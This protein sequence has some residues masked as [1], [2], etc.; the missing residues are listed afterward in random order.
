MRATR[1]VVPWVPALL[2]L[3][4]PG[5]APAI[6]SAGETPPEI[7]WKKLKLNDAFLCEGASFG[8]FDKDGKADVVSGPYWYAGPDFTKRHAL[9]EVHPFDPHKYSDNFFAF[10]YD[11]DKDGW[12][13]VLFIGFPGEGAWWARNPGP[14]LAGDPVWARHDVFKEVSGESPTFVDVNGDGLPD[15][16]GRSHSPETPTSKSLSCWC[17]ATFDPDH[18]EKEW[19]CH[20]ISGDVGEGP[21]FH[22]MGVG[23]INGDG[24]PDLIERTG[25]WEQPKDLKGDPV[26]TQ[27]EVVFSSGH[28]GAQM[29]VTD[30]DGDG[31]ADVITSISAH[32]YGLSWFEQDRQKVLGYEKIRFVE[33]HLMGEKPEECT[34]GISFTELHALA[35]ADVDG[36]G[37][38]D[39]VTGKRFW[40]HGPTGSPGAGD[41]SVLYWWKL[42]RKDG[43]ADFEPHPIDDDSGVGTQV[44]AGDVDGDGKTDVVV[45]NKKGTFVLLQQAAPADG[46]KKQSKGGDLEPREQGSLPLG[47]DGHP[48]NTDFETGDLRD[49]TSEDAAFA[50][51]PVRGDLSAARQRE[52]SR[53]RGDYW[54]GG[55]EL[56][57]D[58]PHGELLS[59]PFKVTK[60]WASFLVGG[61]AGEGTAVELVRDG[62]PQSF[63]RCTGANFESMQPIAVDLHAELGA[64]IRIRLVDDSSDG[65]GHLNFD[66]FRVHDREPKCERALGVPEILTPDPILHA[67]L[68]PAEAAKAMVIPPGFHVDVI[69]GEP[70]VHQPIALAIDGK[71]RL[72]VVEAVSYPWRQKEGEGKDDIVVF[73]DRDGDGTFETRTV[74]A[75]HLNLVSGIEIGFGGVFVGAAPYLEFIPDKNDDLRPDGPP[76]VLLDGFGYEDTHETLNAF[77]WGPDGWLYGCHGVFTHSRVGKPGTPDDQRIPMNAAI[78][79]YQ[80][81][82]HEFEIFAEGTSNPWG[83]DFDDHGDSFC[84]AC[85]IPHLYHIIQ[86]GRYIRQAGEHFEPYGYTEID[87]IADHRHWA[88]SGPYAAIGRSG[89][90]GGGHAHCGALIY[91]GDQFP[92]SFRNTIIMGNIHGNRVN[93]DRFEAKGSGFVG[94]HGPDFILGNDKW[95]RPINE[96]TGPD[97]SVYFI[98]WYDKHACH[99]TPGELWDRTNGRIYRIRYGDLKPRKGDLTL[100]T[101]KR[102]DATN[103]GPVRVTHPTEPERQLVQLQLEKNDW[104]CRQARIELQAWA[105]RNGPRDADELMRRFPEVERSLRGILANYADPTRRL[106]AMWT[107]H[108][109][110]KFTEDDAILLFDDLDPHVRG[111]GVQLACEKKSAGPELLARMAKAAAT[112]DSPIVRRFLASAAQRLPLAD[113]WPIVEALIRHERDADD[114]NLPHL[115]WYALEPLVPADP[116]RALTLALDPK[117][118]PIESLRRFIVRRAAAT[119]A[120]HVTLVKALAQT[121]DPGE[122]RWMLDEAHTALKEQRGL[123]TPAGWPA[124]YEKLRT[125]PDLRREAL[126]VAIDFG[127]ASALPELRAVVIVKGGRGDAAW[128]KRALDAI[129]RAKDPQ[130]PM[131]LMQMLDDPELR[132]PSLRALAGFADDG[133]PYAILATMKA[134]KR[135]FTPDERRD[136]L[137][138]LSARAS[139]AKP[140]LAALGQDE[141]PRADFA[142]TVLRRLRDLR[143]PEVDALVAKHFGVSRESPDDKRQ[144]IAALKQALSP[145]VLSGADHENGRAI[146]SSICMKCH[147]LFGTGRAI[148][149]DLTGANRADL[150]Y[151]LSNVVDPNAVIGKEYQVT[152]VWLK[153]GNVV[154]GI[155]SKENDS[156]LTLIAENETVVVAKSDVESRKLSAVSLMPEGQLDPLSPEDV[157]DLFAY[158]QSPAQVPMKATAASAALLFDQKSLQCWTGD[159]SLWS[160]EQGEIV[161]KTAKGLARNAFL[162]SDLELGDFKLTLEVKLVDDAGN[163]GV[164]FRTEPL[165]P[166]PG[167]PFDFEVKG[168]QADVGPGWWGKLY[169]ENGRGLL[170][171][172]DGTVGGQPFLKK[173]DWNAYEIVATGSRIRLSLNGHVT[174]DVD[175]PAAAKRGRIALQLHSG[176]P[177]EVRF[178]NL[179]LELSPPPLPPAP[180]L[181]PAE[182]R[183]G[184]P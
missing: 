174:A 76:E 60:P 105:A 129:V 180:A 157:R 172:N 94:H 95:F 147:T 143:D 33:H 170:V 50:R 177:T 56:A 150:D 80:P 159:A 67:G 58:G 115:Y 72:W 88:G 127:D 119:A 106:R 149:P 44:V 10:P 123:A 34:H 122:L 81:Q 26:W 98:D 131:L 121:K 146:F 128:R 42:V 110:Q 111:W 86:G 161:G 14:A 61:G 117:R 164:Q 114:V 102:V 120:T 32:A 140:L 4:I 20:P 182:K 103:D 22:G 2:A 108:A 23:D 175:D 45:G 168:C 66:D 173:G 62:E 48:L 68:S 171:D 179:A 160:V 145:D 19:K 107:L 78:W 25:W 59:A 64:A 132:G 37:L 85:V 35:L 9:A 97:G 52:P 124:V 24:R 87:T 152:N 17:Y 71:G 91:L 74:F 27:H 167:G 12:L 30:V 183:A 11:F 84:T 163:S 155:A 5:A 113:R 162:L 54:I 154:S 69:A 136:A 77:N 75:E 83:V 176:G 40:A 181:K 156:A 138:T 92:D 104:W 100:S 16:V 13:D 18:P 184:A 139:W 96:R 169:E 21:F 41:P 89:K 70:D 49:W 73:E 53:H 3:A 166:G 130:A 101:F 38:Q 47:L 36:D 133:T 90:V 144:R 15:L 8:D 65:W 79:R 109:I 29:L 125:N 63:F 148:A 137:T 153:N 142:A 46:A 151:L 57:G 7:A 6:G 93:N 99:S 55:Y 141:V 135:P 178:K 1:S 43:K 126:E 28:G 118:C 112:D 116:P 82:R 51:Q 39:F 134:T 158:L 165:P 31:D